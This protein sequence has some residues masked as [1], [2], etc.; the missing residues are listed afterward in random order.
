MTAP[1][2]CSHDSLLRALLWL[3]QSPVLF[4]PQACGYMAKTALPETIPL[5]TPNQQALESLKTGLSSYPWLPLGIYYEY[6]WQFLIRHHPGLSL[7]THNLQVTQYHQ[8]IKTTTGEYDLI[9]RTASTVY[10][11]ELAVKFYLG[12]PLSDK[13]ESPWQHW[14][15]PGLKDRLDRKMHRLLDHQI[16]L[17]DT[18]EGQQALK[19]FVSGPVKKEILVQGRLFYPMF[20]RCPPP[21][22]INPG[23]LRGYWLTISE[24]PSWLEQQQ[25]TTCQILNKPFWLDN[26]IPED[27]L[28]QAE[29]LSILNRSRQPQMVL[30]NNQYLFVV[31]DSWPE[32][33]KLLAQ[34]GTDKQR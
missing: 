13:P 10:H 6:L 4:S 12:V 22:H 2:Y 3:Q 25:T 8:D 31:P 33:A 18:P 21:V 9:Y 24:Y 29:H 14:A 32:Q 26:R 1:E 17:S 19:A 7:L 28:S 34:A 20:D 30:C 15:G 5:Y 27:T 16:R 11:R 23:H